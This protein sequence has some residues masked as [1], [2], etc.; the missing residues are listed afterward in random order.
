MRY[1]SQVTGTGH[2]AHKRS[3]VENYDY[4]FEN[5]AK[6]SVYQSILKFEKNSVNRIGVAQKIKYE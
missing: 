5:N 4:K 2:Y 3:I 1:R 6:S